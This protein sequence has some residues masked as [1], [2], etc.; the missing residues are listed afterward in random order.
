MSAP[1]ALK[2]IG[3]NV[4]ITYF[5]IFSQLRD[6]K[7][8]AK[9][10]IENGISNESGALIRGRYM[11]HIINNK[12]LMKECVNYIIHHSKKITQAQRNKAKHLLDNIG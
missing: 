5:E 2:G 1:R 8:I 12:I 10:C 3:I 11:E 4:F 6:Q 7:R 9:F